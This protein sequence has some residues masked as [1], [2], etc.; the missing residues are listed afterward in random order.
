MATTIYVGTKT[1]TSTPEALSATSI[2][3][4][5]VL[6][7]SDPTNPTA[8]LIGISSNQY[9]VVR[10]GGEFTISADNVNQLWGKSAESGRNV[11]ANYVAILQT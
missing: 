2:P 5:E 9:H 11:V 10:I 1:F 4:T 7:Q 6:I 8:M 3:C